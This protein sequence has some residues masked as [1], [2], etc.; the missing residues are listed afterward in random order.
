MKAPF[1]PKASI[2]SCQGVRPAR[3]VRAY[4]RPPPSPQFRKPSQPRQRSRV[5]GIG[6]RDRQKRRTPQFRGNPRGSATARRQEKTAQT[7]NPLIADSDRRCQHQGGL[8]HPLY[9]FE[10][11]NCLARS[12]RCYQMQPSVLQVAWCAY[13]SRLLS[14]LDTSRPIGIPKQKSMAKKYRLGTMSLCMLMAH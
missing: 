1:I 14:H 5:R 4:D 7:I 10:T 6:W 2:L 3:C 8:I 12:R 9:H 11:Q 13:Q